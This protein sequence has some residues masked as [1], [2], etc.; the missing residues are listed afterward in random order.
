MRIAYTDDL[1]PP[2]G[3]VKVHDFRDPELGKANPYGIY[4]LAA[5]NGWVGVGTDHDTAA[6]AVETIRR[7]W[8]TVG[9]AAYPA[10]EKLL[11]TADG[12]G[13]NGYRTR[14]WKTE[15]AALAAQTG[16][17]ITVCHLPPGTSKWN[18][19]EHRLFSHISM[20]WRGRPLTSHQVIVDLIGSTTS[21]AGLTVRAELDTDT[22]P[23]GIKIPDKQINDLAETAPCAVTT[24]T[25]SGTTPSPNPRS[26]RVVHRQALSPLREILNVA[27]GPVVILAQ[28]LAHIDRIDSAFLYGSFAARM[29]G[30]AGPAP[31]G[32][33]VMVLGEPDVDAIY[34]AC[35]RIEAAVHRPVN[36]TILTPEEF[37]ASSGFLDHVRSGP[38]VAVVGKLPWR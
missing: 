1:T 21:R 30:D 35:A 31:H 22:Y 10:A 24:G 38:A 14:L 17:A 13:S 26:E 18:K 11:I 12:G 23:T 32:I 33:D 37:T 2:P 25:P 6:F 4:D 27:T 28:E 36:P 8:R 29:V 9:V 19:I 5:D 20:N 7:W 16:L 15:L 34:Q 3:K